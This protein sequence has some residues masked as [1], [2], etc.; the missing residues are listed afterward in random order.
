MDKDVQ[1]A[2]CKLMEPAEA[3]YHHDGGLRYDTNGLG[4]D[5]QHGS[6]APF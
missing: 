2:V 1:A 5:H 6:M 4:G 3:L